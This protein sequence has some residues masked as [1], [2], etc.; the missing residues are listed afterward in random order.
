MSPL[1]VRCVVD[2]N[3][4]TTANAANPGASQQ[5]VTSSAKA[6]QAVMR[7]GHV[8]LDAGGEILREYG[9]NLR[10]SGQPGPGDV[11]FK[12]V[13]TNEWG[14]QRITRVPITS[15]NGDPE[16]FEELPEPSGGV[17]YDRSDRKFLA[18]AAAHAERPPVLQSFDSK[19]WGW[20][21][22]LKE[23]GVTI[24]FLCPEEIAEK[25][26]EKIGG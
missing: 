4:C 16:D 6:L 8:F 10:R 17:S 1:P 18:V 22:S 2:T 11:F 13:L 15:R 9:R 14:G 25:H 5:C 26:R 7:S 3:V 12:W 23:V 24:H 20:Q 21:A 19:W